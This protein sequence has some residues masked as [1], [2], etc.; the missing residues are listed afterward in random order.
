MSFFRQP[1]RRGRPQMAGGRDSPQVG[2]KQCWHSRRV[3]HAGWGDWA[4]PWLIRKRVPD[5]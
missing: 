4:G 2:S 1:S 3:V 5:Y